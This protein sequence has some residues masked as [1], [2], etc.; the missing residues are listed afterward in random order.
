MIKGKLLELLEALLDREMEAKSET[1][2]GSLLRGSSLFTKI[3][4]IFVNKVASSYLDNLF[5]PLFHLLIQQNTT[6]V[7]DKVE[8]ES[9]F[10]A[11]EA[12]KLF[13]EN[14]RDLLSLSQS[15]LDLIVSET[16]VLSMPIL[17][18]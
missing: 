14:I 1:Q 11:E 4:S 13:K 7:I 17:I 16:A 8:L 18:R 5:S 2:K 15:I 12:P 3:E 10:G 6:I 9:K